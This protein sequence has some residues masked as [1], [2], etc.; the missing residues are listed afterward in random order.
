MTLF[1]LILATGSRYILPLLLLFSGFLLLRGHYEPGG[2]FVGG[3]TAAAAF[4]L[5]IIAYGL[6][7][8]Q[9]ILRVN[10][11][12]FIGVGLLLTLASGIPGI[13]AGDP[14]LSGV[15]FIYEIPAIGKVGT[16]L[17]FDV[18]VY[19]VVLGVVMTIIFALAEATRETELEEEGS[20]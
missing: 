13:I 15:W 9:E 7:R 10:P 5:F 17:L 14:F 12:V 19:L 4:T 20:V 18:G 2:G 16:P 1:S 8:T 11:R 3:L 6:E